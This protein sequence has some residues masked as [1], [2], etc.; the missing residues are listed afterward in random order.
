MV[1]VFGPRQSEVKL[2]FTDTGRLNCEVRYTSFAAA[3][4]SKA[5]QGQAEAAAAQAL[6]QALEASAQLERFPKA[7]FDVSAMVLEAGGADAAV[8]VTAASAALADAGVELHDLVSAVQV[9]KCGG[10]L[11][12]DPSLEEGGAAEGSLLLAAM[13]STGEVTHMEVRGR[14]G[15]G[16]LREGLELALGGC[17]QLRGAVREALLAGMEERAGGA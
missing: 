7:V 1:G 17:G 10:Q 15:D 4:A 11:L 6:S 3:R 5:E 16:E 2:G 13:A 9:V 14:W 12:L 8:L